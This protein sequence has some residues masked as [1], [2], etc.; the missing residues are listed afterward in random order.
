MQTTRPCCADL[1]AA[2]GYQ[3]EPERTWHQ[4]YR[5][6][7]GEAAFEDWLFDPAGLRPPVWFQEMPETKAR[8]YIRKH[9]ELECAQQG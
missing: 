4:H 3:P 5:A 9:L 2:L 7:L 8:T 1:G 6:R